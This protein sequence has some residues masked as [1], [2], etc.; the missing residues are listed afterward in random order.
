MHYTTVIPACK[1]SIFP[2]VFSDILP[3]RFFADFHKYNYR[4]FL[5][6]FLTRNSEFQY[7]PKSFIVIN[8]RFHNPLIP[9]NIHFGVLHS[10]A[11]ELSLFS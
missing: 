9:V 6:I 11:I 10:T 2:S 1:N 4:I 3:V 5:V 8:I 7:E